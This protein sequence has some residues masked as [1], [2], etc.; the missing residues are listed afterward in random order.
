MGFFILNKLQ[1]KD[2]CSNSS[3]RQEAISLLINLESSV[4]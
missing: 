2:D 1:V 3:K 4:S